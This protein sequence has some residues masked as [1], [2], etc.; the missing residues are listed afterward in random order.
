MTVADCLTEAS[1]QQTPWLRVLGAWTGKGVGYGAALGA[2]FG[3]SLAAALLQNIG[4][5]EVGAPIGAVLG[6]AVGLATGF[7]DGLVLAVAT[8]TSLLGPSAPNRTARAM[9]VAAMTTSAI[10][11]LGFGLVLLAL[12]YHGDGGWVIVLPP[13]T[14]AVTVSIWLARRLPPGRPA[15][16]RP[17][18]SGRAG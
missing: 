12:N 2:L 16:T 8:A 18:G 11:G 10:S 1:E 14:I 9:A 17:T 5:A 4:E 7:I 6:A 13:T 3:G 15:R